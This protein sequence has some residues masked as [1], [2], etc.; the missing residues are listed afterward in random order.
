ME[1]EYLCEKKDVKKAIKLILKVLQELK[2]SPKK[3]NNTG[4][5][6]MLW[7]INKDGK[8]YFV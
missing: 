4:Y 2:I 5:T 8:K 7:D 1:I 6:K 3:I